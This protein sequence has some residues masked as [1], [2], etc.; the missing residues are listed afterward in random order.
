MQN[1][2]QSYDDCEFLIKKFYDKLLLDEQISHFF[3]SLDLDEHIPKVASFWAFILLD[4]AGYSS[5]MMAAHQKLPLKGGDFDRWL[6]LFH[7]TIDEHFCGEKAT[8]AKERSQLI[9]M[10]LRLKFES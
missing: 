6:S 10:T 9:A 5:N 1:D 3:T 2:I 4:Q 7:T 8:M